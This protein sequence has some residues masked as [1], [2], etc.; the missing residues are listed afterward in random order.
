MNRGQFS[1]SINEFH[2]RLA[3][4]QHVDFG[5]FE[6]VLSSLEESYDPIDE[7]SLNDL[8]EVYSYYQYNNQY[9]LNSAELTSKFELI[10]TRIQ[11]HRE[12]LVANGIAPD[13]VLN[14]S[15]QDKV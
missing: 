11:R 10:A 2:N 13:Y 4:A 15:I 1:N 7:Y 3:C 8:C 6:N 12:F 9:L 14:W 5:L